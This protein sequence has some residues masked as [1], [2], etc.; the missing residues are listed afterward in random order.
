MKLKFG[1]TVHAATLP[2]NCNPNSTTTFAHA[3]VVIA[4]RLA[5]SDSKRVTVLSTLAIP[6]AAAGVIEL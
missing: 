3:N 5:D 6:Q 2:V 1:Q 4:L